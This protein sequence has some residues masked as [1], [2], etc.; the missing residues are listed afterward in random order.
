MRWLP[1]GISNCHS[2][3]NIEFSTLPAPR[4]SGDY[5]A[6]STKTMALFCRAGL[7]K[8]HCIQNQQQQADAC[9]DQAIQ[10]NALGP[11]EDRG[12]IDY[13]SNDLLAI[14]PICVAFL[15]WDSVLRVQRLAASAS[16]NIL[17]A[18]D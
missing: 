14:L 4:P 11:V 15:I 3:I 17:P 8:A 5:L 6:K 1:N 7:L 13:Q 2:T 16:M 9:L 10:L 12:A 18:P